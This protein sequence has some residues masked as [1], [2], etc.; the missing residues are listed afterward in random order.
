MCLGI[1]KFYL[2]I[3]ELFGGI[4]VPPKSNGNSPPP[5]TSG[6][7]TQVGQAQWALFRTGCWLG[8]CSVIP[9][10]EIS[11]LPTPIASFNQIHTTFLCLFCLFVSCF[12]FFPSHIRLWSGLTPDSILKDLSWKAQ[13]AICGA[14]RLS[15]SWPCAN[16][17]PNPLYYQS[18]TRFL[19]FGSAEI[20]IS[21]SSL[22]FIHST[23][24]NKHSLPNPRKDWLPLVLL[25]PHSQMYNR[26]ENLLWGS[27]LY[28]V[29][30]FSS[31]IFK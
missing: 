5:Q 28:K 3:L 26:T 21:T 8:P 30:S 24:H 10:L 29:T 22:C 25:R 1:Y 23:F 18:S 11:Q 6:W 27:H 2:F 16:Q 4:C 9:V 13:R 19:I 31:F 12:C 15:P 7:W 17:V 20:K 14:R